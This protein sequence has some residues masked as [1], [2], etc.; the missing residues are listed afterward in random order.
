MTGV[1]ISIFLHALM[2]RVRAYSL[3]MPLVSGCHTGFCGEWALMET[4]RGRHGC[5]ARSLFFGAS[6]C[7]FRKESAPTLSPRCAKQVYA[8]AT[9]KSSK[10]RSLVLK[11]PSAR[12]YQSKGARPMSA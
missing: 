11:N 2:V 9:P 4:S 8:P 3:A 1:S 5:I 7:G 10:V 6:M 12:L